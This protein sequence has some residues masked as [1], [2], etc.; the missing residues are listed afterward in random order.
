LAFASVPGLAIGI[1]ALFWPQAQTAASVLASATMALAI[2][3]LPPLVVATARSR[4]GSHLGA[5]HRRA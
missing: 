4:R 5:T 1:G 2:A 3:L